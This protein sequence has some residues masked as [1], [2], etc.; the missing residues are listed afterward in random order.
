[1]LTDFFKIAANLKNI[2]RQGWVEKLKINNPESVADH[3][4][5]TA[6]ISMVHSDLQN[7]D[8]AKVLKMSLLHD[9]AES[10]VGDITPNMS[11]YENKTAL[12]TKT[13]KKIL[14]NIPNDL[15]KEYFQI[16]IEYVENKSR[17][18]QL[19]HEA[20]KLEMVL[21]A[22]LYEKNG[23]DKNNL[24]SFY[25]TADKGIKTSQMRKILS[26]LSI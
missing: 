10:I 5:S 26:E 22:K 16:W 20:D 21:Q 19:V 12:E 2:R 24:I 6:I 3:T 14:K 8:T 18:A 15:E 25:N 1:M 17:E 9:L 13:F 7:L 11:N 4:F 23:Y